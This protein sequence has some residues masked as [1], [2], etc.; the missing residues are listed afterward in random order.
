MTSVAREIF[1]RHAKRI[2]AEG[3]WGAVDH[4]MLAAYAEACE[5][6]LAC[7]E[8]VDEYGV[9]I[10]GRTTSSERVKN[11]ALVPLNQ[12]REAMRRLALTVPLVDHK[13]AGERADWDRFL[14]EI[15]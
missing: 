7:K 9:L 8:A 3:R 11:P 1:D 6:Y 4:D 13:A 15:S 5:I 12:A 2:S 10:P 14:E